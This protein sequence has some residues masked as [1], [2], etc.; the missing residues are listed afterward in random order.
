MRR[1]V[2]HLRPR[3]VLFAGTTEGRKLSEVLAAAGIEHTICVATEYGEIVL[4]NHPLVKI[5]QGR[6]NREEMGAFV[7]E[8]KFELVIDATHPFAREATQNI[9]AAVGAQNGT[10]E[11]PSY[12]RLKREET[13][14]ADSG[15][16]YFETSEDCALA[17]T[18]TQ[19]NILLTTGSKELFWYCKNEAVRSRLYVRILPSKESLALCEEQGICGKQILAM[20]GPFTEGLNEA[21]IRQYQI[22]CLVTKESGAQGGY[23]E[24]L[25]AAKRTGAKVFVIGRPQE[26]AG[27][28]FAQM[29]GELEKRCGRKLSGEGGLEITLAGIG[30]GK[31]DGL[32]KEA[33]RAVKEADLL[34]GAK[35]LL[36]VLPSKAEKHPFYQASQIVPFLQKVQESNRF[37]ENRK[38]VILFSGDSGFYSGCGSLYAALDK[39]ICEG[40]LRASLQVLPGIS[41]VAYLA[42]C[43]GESYHDAAV[44]SMH[45]KELYNLANRI[46]HNAKT[47]LLTSGV[48]D[49]NRLGE[50][51]SKAGMTA[52]EVI[53]GYQL[54]YPKQ[55]IVRLSPAECMERKKEG[56]YTCLIKN[57]YAEK[58]KLTHGIADRQFIRGGDSTKI[59]PMTKE[60][61][62]EISIC[63]L[64]LREGAV[65]YDI[66]SGTGSV[67]AEIAGLSDEI[68]VYAVEQR[69]EAVSLLEE[70]RK[71]FGL[72]NIHV[73]NTTAPEGLFELPTPTQAFIGGS[74]GRLKEI[75]SALYQKNGKMRVVMNAVS[76]ETFCEIK[77]IL[78]LY[79]IRDTEIVQVQINRVRETGE[80]HL[81]RAENPVW[82][83]AFTFDGV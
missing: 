80:Y 66:G 62:R 51:L 76:M 20:Q 47:F 64:H 59:I 2:N 73:I 53:A 75:L 27:Y 17:L 42:S 45:G 40:R 81:M 23:P 30:M 15:E 41:S 34:L 31:E 14:F 4:K 70:N 39:E 36:T 19:G 10:G 7:K 54:S 48:Q 67:A 74:G 18:Q 12:L 6:M 16:V 79:R 63:K 1:T 8:G 26:E 22:S 72:Q 11:K 78:S 38:V 57:P 29:C 82:I 83:C 49:V 46:K 68:E 5:R 3:I 71:K 9:K 58:R 50:E 33:E 61:V 28:S 25:E 56:L 13:K 65:V 69:K 24:K 21:L 44:Y 35:R 32:T 60:E 52:C 55:K 77:E 43:V 37:G